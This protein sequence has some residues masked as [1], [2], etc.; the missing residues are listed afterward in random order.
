MDNKK[1]LLP[2]TK[3]PKVDV[4]LLTKPPH[5]DCAR[6]CL[7]L[8][9]LSENA[10]LYLSGDGVY[11]LLGDALRALPGEQIFAC[12]EDLEAR[13]VQPEV[14]AAIPDDFYERLVKDI[15]LNGNRIYTF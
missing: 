10:V 6:F 8:I 12:K 14:M 2:D 9:M 15:M 4:F 7:Q 3:E 11:N 1:R 5:S 13:G